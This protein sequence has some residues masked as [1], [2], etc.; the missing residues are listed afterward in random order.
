MQM[1]FKL[2]NFQNY[3]VQFR[4]KDIQVQ[5]IYCIV[6][7]FSKRNLSSEKNVLVILNE[8]PEVI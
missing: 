5:I 6:Y 7:F 2:K 3:K 8:I 1:P 4:F